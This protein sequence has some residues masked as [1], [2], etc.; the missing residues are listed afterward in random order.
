M[1][2][3]VQMSRWPVMI[4]MTCCLFLARRATS[5][6]HQLDLNQILAIT[7]PFSLLVNTMTCLSDKHRSRIHR[8]PTDPSASDDVL[9]AELWTSFPGRRNVMV[10]NVVFLY[11]NWLSAS[12]E[13]Q[14]WDAYTTRRAMLGPRTA[15]ENPPTS[16]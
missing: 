12:T 10:W 9:L 11:S 14:Q 2:K 7:L 3:A 5:G 6:L 15:G 8:I 1:I 16:V 4:Q 13:T